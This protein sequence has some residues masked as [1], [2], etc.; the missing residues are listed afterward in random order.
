MHRADPAQGQKS[1]EPV[2]L[3]LESRGG[4]G[5]LIRRLFQARHY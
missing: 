4:C 1:L 5:E 3:D 2:V